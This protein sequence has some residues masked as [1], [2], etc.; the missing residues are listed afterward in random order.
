MHNNGMMTWRA[1]QP[2]PQHG[3]GHGTPGRAGPMPVGTGDGD[4]PRSPANRGWRRGW[5]PGPRQ[6]GDG[7]GDGPPIPGTGKSGMGPPSPMGPIPGKSGMAVGM[8][9]GGSVPCHGAKRVH[10]ES[11]SVPRHGHTE[12]GV[13]RL[14]LAFSRN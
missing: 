6:I 11:A 13:A 9:I 7:G 10:S 5:T 3:A 8:G 2:E 14:L 12:Q 1:G 4:D